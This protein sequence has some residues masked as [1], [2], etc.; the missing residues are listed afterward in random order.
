MKVGVIFGGP[1]AE[2]GVS[3]ISAAAV[4]RGLR[5]ASHDVIPM[6]VDK[7]AKWCSNAQSTEILDSVGSTPAET[8][9][10][11]GN[12]PIHPGLLDREVDLVFPVLHGPWGEDGTIQGL[13]EAFG[14]P[15]VGCGI[16]SSA[17]CMDK[18]RCKELVSRAGIPTARWVKFIHRDNPLEDLEGQTAKLGFPLFVKPARMGSSVGISRVEK[19]QELHDAIVEAFRWDR[20]ILMEKGLDARE[21]EIS[22]LGNDNPR[23]S[24]PGEVRPTEGFYDFQGKYLDDSTEL[25]AP[26]ILDQEQIAAIGKTALKIY[27]ILGCEGMARVDLFI[28]KASGQIFFNEV[29]TIPGFTSISMYPKLWEVTGLP[30]PELLNELLRLALNRHLRD[31]TS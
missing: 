22:V 11:S 17:L 13:L 26:A 31:R 20:E 4:A 25:I 16:E 18:I 29:N 12:L 14:L 1:S 8:P 23:A 27:S 10:F 3:L 30:F 19:V 2:H 5:Q 15:Y 21:I 28:E 6:A 7:D 9:D 24:L